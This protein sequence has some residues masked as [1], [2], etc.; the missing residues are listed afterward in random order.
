MVK[1]SVETPE[2]LIEQGISKR[3]MA[4]YGRSISVKNVTKAFLETLIGRSMKVGDA[5]RLCDLHDKIYPS[6]TR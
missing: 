3:Y 4:R 1:F 5:L 2:S 6:S